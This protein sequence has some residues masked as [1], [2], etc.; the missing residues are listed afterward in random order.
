LYWWVVFT[1]GERSV[2]L[3][4]VDRVLHFKEPGTVSESSKL[5]I[6]LESSA[7]RDLVLQTGNEQVFGSWLEALQAAH[8]VSRSALIM[9]QRKRKEARTAAAEAHYRVRERKQSER[10]ERQ[11]AR[12]KIRQK[13]CN[14]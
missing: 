11:E 3:T 13:W 9:E 1:A 8:H 4:D 10:Q 14:N 7:A 6:K 5:V 12:N 2:T